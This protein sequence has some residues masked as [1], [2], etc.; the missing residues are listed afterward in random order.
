MFLIWPVT[1]QFPILVDCESR[2][3]AK[4]NKNM[5]G[6]LGREQATYWSCI[7]VNRQTFYFQKQQK[8]KINMYLFLKLHWLTVL[9][10]NA[11]NFYID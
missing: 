6:L 10:T 7:R 5:Y 1:Y 4:Y 8:I 9:K 3:P 2:E 11:V